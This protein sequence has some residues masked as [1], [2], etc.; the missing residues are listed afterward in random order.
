MDWFI[1]DT[2]F[3]R[4]SIIEYRNR[5]YL[6]VEEM[7]TRLIANINRVVKPEDRLFHLGNFAF[8]KARSW[9]NQIECDNIFLI[10][11]P[12]DKNLGYEKSLFREVHQIFHLQL[13]VVGM[14][15]HVVLCHYP[16]LI[17]PRMNDGAWH[18]HSHTLGKLTHDPKKLCLD[19]GVDCTN[20]KPISLPEVFAQMASKMV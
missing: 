16:L 1:A 12:M 15:K 19:V 10:Q 8:G 9:R 20:Y 7:N 5:P 11:G 2:Q 14:R 13:N 4:K 17:W 6:D 18:L 3:N